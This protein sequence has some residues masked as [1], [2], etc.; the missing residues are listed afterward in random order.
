M[1]AARNARRLAS[2]RM[3]SQA[4]SPRA[5]LQRGAAP[6][7]AW[8]QSN[9]RLLLASGVI[10]LLI[11]IVPVVNATR[12]SA[13]GSIS[14]TPSASP[15]VSCQLKPF[16]HDQ[17]EALMEAGAVIAYERNGGSTCLDELYGIFPDGRITGDDGGQ[18]IE[19]QVSPEE[20]EQLLI[21]IRD[22]GWFTDEMYTT[23]HTPCGQCYS[24]YLTVL[25]EGQVKT[26]QAVDGGTDAPA[27]YWQV[28]SRINGVTP[29]FAAN[30]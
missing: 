15:S 14:D 30:P 23:S 9:R 6:W 8:L 29:K 21:D 2:E 7:R 10:V 3:R 5:A 27:N 12:N 24:Y 1:L 19:K 13:R 22:K 4:K 28:V 17:A 16:R 20:V 25:H 11:L 18:Q 26:V